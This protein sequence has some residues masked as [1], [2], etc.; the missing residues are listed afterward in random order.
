MMFVQNNVHLLKQYIEQLNEIENWFHVYNIDRW[1]FISSSLLFAYQIT[2]NPKMNDNIHS[3]FS[4]Q[5]ISKVKMIDL[6]H[7]F[8]NQGIDD[9]YL[10]GLDKLKHYLQA[11]IDSSTD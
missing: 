11:A 7:V 2:T 4:R 9:N 1:K 8:P 3:S 10:F 6:A 5:P